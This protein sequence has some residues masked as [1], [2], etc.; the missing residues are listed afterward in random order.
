MTAEAEAKQVLAEANRKANQRLRVGAVALGLMLVGA[1]GAGWVAT[2]SLSNAEQLAKK[3]H[4]LRK[5]VSSLEEKE[6]SLQKQFE[7]VNVKRINAEN[8][9]KTAEQNLAEAKKQE[10]I[11]RQQYQQTQQQLVQV[12]QAKEKA[13]QETAQAK[14]HAQE[15]IQTAKSARTQAE[16]AKKD[17]ERAKYELAQVNKQLESLKPSLRKALTLLTDFGAIDST[18][19]LVNRKLDDIFKLLQT[20]AQGIGVSNIPRIEKP[21]INTQETQEAAKKINE[22]VAYAVKFLNA[23]FNFDLNVPPVRILDKNFL[24]AFWDGQQYNA[25][26]QIQYL[27]DVT[28]HQIALPFIYKTVEFEVYG[29]PA[30]LKESYADI[31]A[32]LIKQTRLQQ[33]AQT[34]DWLFAP[35]GNAWI[36]N[37]DILNFKD[38]SAFRSL[39]A[40][41]TAYDHP[42][43]GKDPQV[44]HFKDLYTGSSDN[45]GVHINSGIPNKAFYETAI[46][47]GSDK[48]GQIWYK[49]LLKLNPNSQFRDAA[50]STY[51]V[52]GTL[53]GN[54]STEQRAVKTAWEMVGI[55]LF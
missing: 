55:S 47:I 17:R 42:A 20:S 50:M 22:D 38:Q 8:A 7:T 6:I 18:T 53:Y 29:Q 3:E 49:A 2:Q 1:A 52:A 11:I 16:A 48:A 23:L 36:L 19:G 35:G 34:A 41:G 45:G 43:L 27:P 40:P 30:S 9:K 25:P 14:L 13:I 33:T 15:A 54:D 32:S 10:E 51:Q 24:N 12:N 31:F 26:P 5:K 39:K 46:R 44:A 28:Y 21:S 37:Q 4:E